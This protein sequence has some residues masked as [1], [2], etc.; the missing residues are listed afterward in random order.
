[1]YLI[2]WK[3]Y[4]RNYPIIFTLKIERYKTK[5]RICKIEEMFKRFLNFRLKF[6][7][8]VFSVCKS[9]Y[10]YFITWCCNTNCNLSKHTLNILN[11]TRLIYLCLVLILN[12]HSIKR[13]VNKF[14]DSV[15]LIGIDA[16]ISLILQRM[17][18]SISWYL[19][20]RF[21]QLA[22]VHSII[23]S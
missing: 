5:H 20:W 14:S 17:I 13:P 15:Q 23:N 1:M 12:G 4:N 7:A 3:R 21:M 22:L 18:T 10:V 16:R 6:F 19:K 2:F 9:I 8:S 11:D